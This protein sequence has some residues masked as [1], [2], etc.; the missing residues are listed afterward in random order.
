M[1][2]L[3][4]ENKKLVCNAQGMKVYIKLYRIKNIEYIWEFDNKGHIHITS[5]K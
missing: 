2:R 5:L 3:L 4:Y 1:R